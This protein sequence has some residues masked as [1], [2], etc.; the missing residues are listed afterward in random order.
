MSEEA[1]LVAAGELGDK[2]AAFLET[3]IGMYLLAARDRDEKEAQ[4]SLLSLDPYQYD[5]L[6]KLQ[7]AI[8]AAQENVVLA[9]KVQGYLGDAIINGRQAD[10]LLMSQEDE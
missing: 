1:D 9:R 10:Q 3:E 5:S 8:A 7:A 2:V 4:E 6:G